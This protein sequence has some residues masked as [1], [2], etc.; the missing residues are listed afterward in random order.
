MCWVDLFRNEKGSKKKERE[1]EK[2]RERGGGQRIFPFA[3]VPALM[4]V[5]S[6]S[7]YLK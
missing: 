4:Q 3:R 1:G 6:L 2:E 7:E 5:K